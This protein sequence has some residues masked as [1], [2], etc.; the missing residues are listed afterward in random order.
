[1]D[2]FFSKVIHKRFLSW[3]FFA[4][5]LLLSVFTLAFSEEE[6]EVTIT[7]VGDLYLG[8]WV[9]KTL[10][11]NPSYPFLY[12][13]EIFSQGDLLFGNLESPLSLHDEIFME[14]TFL[15]RAHPDT[16]QTLVAGGFDAL[17]LANNHIM[18][19]GPVALADTI[20]LLDKYGIKHAG[21]GMTLKAARSL[22]ILEK[23]GLKVALLAFNNSLPLEF[24]A[25]ISRPGTAKGDRDYISKDVKEASA[26]ADLVIVSFHWSAEHLKTPKNYQRS[27]GKLCIDSGADLVFGHHP[28]V[29]QGIERYKDGLIAY[30]L[31]NFVF[32]SYS[33]KVREAIILQVK[34]GPSG[35][36]EAR[37]YPININNYEVKFRPQRLRGEEAMNALNELKAL[38]SALGTEI[39]IHDETGVIFF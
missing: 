26:F 20:T 5:L 12:T 17:T 6:A 24:N 34:M 33:Q 3:S 32:A 23:N 8:G 2:T 39:E 35:L 18:D 30:S 36:K 21:A 29:I 37:I 4:C 1:M 10:L 16:V 15:L 7:M 28:H 25:G 14:K 38:S 31:G 22:A 11:T 9:E 13:Q 27:L 19:Y